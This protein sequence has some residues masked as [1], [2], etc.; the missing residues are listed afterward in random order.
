MLR[1]SV[2]AVTA[3]VNAPVVWSAFVAQTVPI[4]AVL[5]RLL[6]TLPI[7]AVLVA[8]VRATAGRNEAASTSRTTPTAPDHPS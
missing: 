2:L 4:E 8:F 3:L 6:V 1:W 7:I 5:I